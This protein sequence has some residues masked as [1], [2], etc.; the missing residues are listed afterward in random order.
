MMMMMFVSESTDA[1]DSVAETVYIIGGVVGGVSVLIVIVVVSWRCRRQQRYHHRD[2]SSIS[3]S[4]PRK[5]SAT[6]FSEDQTSMLLP[7]TSFPIID[8]EIAPSSVQILRRIGNARFGTVYIGNFVT[9]LVA[10]NPVIIKTLAA[11]A[12][13][14]TR[15]FFIA[16]T[17]VMVGL[18]HCNVLGLVGACLQHSSQSGIISA[19]YEHYDGVDLNTLLQRQRTLSRSLHQT[20]LLMKLAVDSACGLMYLSENSLN[21]ADV[22]SNNILV[23]PDTS[24]SAVT[25]K[26]CDFGLP[27]PWCFCTSQHHC[28][29]TGIHSSV[30]WPQQP[31]APELLLYGHVAITEAT[32]VWQFGIILY[33][34]HNVIRHQR[35]VAIVT[36]CC[37]DEPAQRPTFADIHHR[38]LAASVTFDPITDPVIDRVTGE[39]IW[40]CDLHRSSPAASN[41]TGYSLLMVHRDDRPTI[42]HQYDDDDDDDDDVINQY[43][44]HP[45]QQPCRHD[46]NSEMIDDEARQNTHTRSV[47]SHFSSR[48]QFIV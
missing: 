39:V 41:E 16:R 3:A 15:E 42:H 46:D 29:A 48:S 13:P 47:S 6:N 36:D 45:H 2:V 11:G 17:R 19:L 18:K 4:I 23:V 20:A 32:D 10:S 38:L 9:S 37:S 22:T 24:G 21:H 14:A 44:Y 5:P 12:D 25:A 1:G 28:A 30:V 7:A 34:I 40:E 31:P 35:L 43:Q 33:Q 8:L 26:V 27:S